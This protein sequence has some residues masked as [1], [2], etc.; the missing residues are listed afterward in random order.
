MV[1][2]AYHACAPRSVGLEVLG[3]IRNK[4]M[5]SKTI[6][7]NVARYER[8]YDGSNEMTWR[9][10]AYEGKELIEIVHGGVEVIFRVSKSYDAGGRRTL[11][12]TKTPAPNVI[13]VGH[14]PWKWIE[15]IAPEGD[16]FDGSAI[17]FVRHRAPGRRPYNFIT[18]REAQPVAFGPNNRDYFPQIPELGTWRPAARPRLARLRKALAPEQEDGGRRSAAMARRCLMLIRRSGP[19][20]LLASAPPRELRPQSTPA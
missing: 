16:E 17:F 3:P 6:I 10:Y 4:G 12:A 5:N 9:G 1:G 11:S 14:I 18:Y 19:S 13:E 7:M 20:K 2:C 15:D 8:G